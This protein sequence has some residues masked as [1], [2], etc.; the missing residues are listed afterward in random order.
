MSGREDARPRAVCRRSVGRRVFCPTLPH[1][2]RVYRTIDRSRTARRPANKP[3]QHNCH[4]RRNRARD[5][6][7]GRSWHIGSILGDALIPKAPCAPSRAVVLHGLL[8]R[9]GPRSRGLAVIT[10]DHQLSAPQSFLQIER[11][12]ERARAL[13]VGRCLDARQRRTIRRWQALPR[14]E[15]RVCFFFHNPRVSGVRPRQ[16]SP[17]LQCSANATMPPPWLSR[18]SARCLDR[19]SSTGKLPTASGRHRV[20][21]R[22]LGSSSSHFRPEC[23]EPTQLGCDRRIARCFLFLGVCPCS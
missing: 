14:C 8:P 3:R 17:G 9:R 16:C 22:Q 10:G 1:R 21:A 12:A 23:Q 20:G 6:S 13:T 4:D 15:L 2:P 19:H 18:D 11:P 7:L 5:W